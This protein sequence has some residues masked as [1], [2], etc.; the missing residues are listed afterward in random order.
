MSEWDEDSLIPF[1]WN[2][3]FVGMK[4]FVLQV[5]AILILGVV[6][7]RKNGDGWLAQHLWER[8]ERPRGLYM[9]LVT[10]WRS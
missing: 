9:R 1:L 7:G 3:R 5:L 6:T 2:L 10:A 8:K 4:S